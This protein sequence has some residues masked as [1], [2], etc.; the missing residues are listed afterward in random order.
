MPAVV[1]PDLL[2]AILLNGVLLLIVLIL[3]LALRRRIRDSD[4]RQER[5]QDQLDVLKNK[6]A[7]IE[8]ALFYGPSAPWTTENR[9]EKSETDPEVTKGL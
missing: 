1:Q 2:I 7:R 6:M 9:R 3:C 8:G 5:Q 4:A